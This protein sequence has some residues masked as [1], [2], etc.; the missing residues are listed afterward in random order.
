MI[1]VAV[2]QD[3]IGQLEVKTK[4]VHF[5]VQRNNTFSMP[6]AVI[7]FERARLNEGGAF[8]LAS[9]IF[10]VPVTGIYHFEFFAMKHNAGDYLFIYLQVNGANVGCA[11][12]G[13]ADSGSKTHDVVSLSSSLRL[14]AGD[15]VNLLNNYFGMM[16]DNSNHHTHFTGWLVEEELM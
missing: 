15:R 16:F 12:T 7:P 4:T 10:T 14:A 2:S 6:G 8:N 9:G 13:Y 1:C 3:L 5:Y 11:Y